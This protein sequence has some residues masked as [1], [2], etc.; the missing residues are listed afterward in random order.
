MVSCMAMPTS[1]PDLYTW[2][3]RWQRAEALTAGLVG[4]LFLL[5]GVVVLLHATDRPLSHAEIAAALPDLDPDRFHPMLARID[6]VIF[7]TRDPPGL[8]LSS[9]LRRRLDG[10]G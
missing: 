4:A 10:R 8:M 5:A 3:R 1:D 6:G 7:L 2:F 9:D